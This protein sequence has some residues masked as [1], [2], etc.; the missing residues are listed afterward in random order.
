MEDIPRSAS[1]SALQKGLV[2]GPMRHEMLRT[3]SCCCLKKG[4]GL[5]VTS[6]H[7]LLAL[8]VLCLRMLGG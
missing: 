6:I 1:A 2:G 8:M 5:A 3:L 4:G 7:G